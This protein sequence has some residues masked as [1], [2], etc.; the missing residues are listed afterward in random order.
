MDRQ[1]LYILLQKP[2]GTK[3]DFKAMLSLKT[4]SEKKELAKDVAAIANSKGG[5]GYIIY[6]IED[7]TKAILGIEGKYYTEEQIQQIISQRCDPPVS[8]K[9]ETI[10]VDD[11]QIA[12]LTIYRS[13][14]KP[15]Q[16][17]Q[18]GVFYIRRGSTTDIARREE[19]A[20]MLQESGILQHERI[21]LNRVELKELDEEIIN[22]YIS[23]TGLTSTNEDYYTLLEGVGIIGRDEDNNGYHP[24]VGGLLVFGYH[25]QLYLPHSGIRLIDKCA[26]DEI[27]YFS[28][29][30]IR[31]LDEIENYLKAKAAKINE[32]Y[33]VAAVI[34]AIANAA[35]HRDYFSL[36]RE[37]VILI[38]NSKIEISNPGSICSD[39]DMQG[40]MEEYNPCRRNQ[41]L[42]QRLLIL[43]NKGRFLKT[44][45]GM[46][47]IYE[48]FR[49]HGGARFINNEKRNLFKVV[50]PGMIKY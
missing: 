27:I 19:I 4:E 17:R 9:L 29:H 46:K 48:A 1:K 40:L 47:R 50:L 49:Q 30:I 35:V 31:M 28:G 21:V 10:P 15:H 12:V 34:E 24:T 36:G 33:P 37:I 42:Y 14:Q 44:G 16:I 38:E 45:T 11:K 39:D 8:V 26:A 20:S 6:G 13:S 2:E 22:Y 23:K 18:T 5:R 41:W 7:G 43:D 32:K 25:P 3:L